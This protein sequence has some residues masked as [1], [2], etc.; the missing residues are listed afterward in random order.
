MDSSS[1]V[2][3]KLFLVGSGSAMYLIFSASSGL[4]LAPSGGGMLKAYHGQEF[5]AKDGFVKV[6][7][8]FGITGEIQIRIDCAHFFYFMMSK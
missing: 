2:A 5:T 3:I 4:H 7:G 1:L 6:E 8:R